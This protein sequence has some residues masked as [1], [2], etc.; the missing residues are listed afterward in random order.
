[1]RP[2]QKDSDS[3]PDYDVLDAILYRYIEMKE[4]LAAIIN[5]GFSKELVEKVITLV[6]RSEYKRFQSP[7]ILRVSSKAF[8]IGRRMPIVARY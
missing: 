6:N 4:P 1:L 2:N 8:G 5:A 3:L 7:P